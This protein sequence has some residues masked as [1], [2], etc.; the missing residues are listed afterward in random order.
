[1]HAIQTQELSE[2]SPN[3]P[4]SHGVSHQVNALCAGAAASELV[5]AGHHGELRSLET[6]DFGREGGRKGVRN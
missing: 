3:L 4:L 5:V 2:T 1:M 6:K